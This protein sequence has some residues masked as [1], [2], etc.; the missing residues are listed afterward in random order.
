MASLAQRLGL[1]ADRGKRSMES[2]RNRT[3]AAVGTVVQAVEITGTAAFM[4]WLRHRMDDPATGRNE[5]QVLGI[6]PELLVGLGGHVATIFGLTGRWGEHVD[7]V[8]DGALAAF[9]YPIAAAAGTQARQRAMARA[10]GAPAGISGIG[11]FLGI[12]ARRAPALGGNVTPLSVAA[13]MRNMRAR[14]A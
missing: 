2:T 7:N 9:V 6:D 14:A 1:Q 10:A 5:F 12:G 4:A 3:A 13:A 8:S 11:R